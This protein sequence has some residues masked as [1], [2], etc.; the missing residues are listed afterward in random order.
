[1]TNRSLKDKLGRSSQLVKATAGKYKQEHPDWFKFFLGNNKTNRE[2]YSPVLVDM[3]EKELNEYALAPEGWMVNKALAIL[4]DKEFS[5]VQKAVNP[6]KKTN[7]DWFKFFLGKGGSA[8]EHY[9]PDLVEAIRKEF[10]KYDVAPDGWLTSGATATLV[11][12]NAETVRKVAASYRKANPEW[13]KFFLAKR[14]GLVEHYS[15]DLLVTI[16]NKFS[17]YELAPD[18][19]ANTKEVLDSFK[20]DAKMVRRVLDSYRETNPE[21]YKLFLDKR[22][23]VTEHYS[24]EL[25]AKVRRDLEIKY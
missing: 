5:T 2:H 12:K 23:I 1:M 15:P 20:R 3:I 22:G 14:G 8:G 7:P 13:F 11:G 10:G 18:S 24:A 17:Q 16:K 6:Y 25:V 4:V 19:W 21:W 9:S